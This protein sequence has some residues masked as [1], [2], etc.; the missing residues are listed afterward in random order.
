MRVV[1]HGLD[2]P[3]L[4]VGVIV[5]PDFRPPEK[6]IVG[7]PSEAGV[8]LMVHDCR[9]RR[10]VDLAG[11]GRFVGRENLVDIVGENVVML[12]AEMKREVAAD[13]DQEEGRS[14]VQESVPVHRR[15][16]LYQDSY[17]A[18]R[19]GS[20]AAVALLS[21]SR[22]VPNCLSNG[23]TA[24]VRNRRGVIPPPPIRRCS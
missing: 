10:R 8:Q 6:Q 7:T 5:G 1:A 13:P 24:R 11:H 2:D 9:Q 3:E 19:S 17:D 21:S 16:E 23:N 4:T 14:P 12:Q 20:T 22:L 18:A 15:K